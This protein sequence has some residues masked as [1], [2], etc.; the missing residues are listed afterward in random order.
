MRLMDVSGEGAT[1]QRN[2]GATRSAPV[3]S[4][5]RKPEIEAQGVSLAQ[6]ESFRRAFPSRRAMQ[7]PGGTLRNNSL[8]P[9]FTK[10]D[11]WK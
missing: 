2:R 5:C 4:F 3:R 11:G 6:S 9:L 7:V 8:S 1:D 10:A